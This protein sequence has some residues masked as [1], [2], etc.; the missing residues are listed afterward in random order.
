M[1]TFATVRGAPAPAESTKHTLADDLGALKE[2]VAQLLTR[3]VALARAELRQEAERFLVRGVLFG[4]GLMWGSVGY[5]L[6]MG[7]LVS[8]LTPSL[9]RPI[10][11]S[12]VGLV[13]LSIG[14]VLVVWVSRRGVCDDHPFARSAAEVEEDLRLAHRPTPSAGEPSAPAAPIIDTP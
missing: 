3:H 2:N 8:L 5:L 12:A 9:G 4:V 11:A 6:L 14:A 7:A 1:S 10:A 13:N